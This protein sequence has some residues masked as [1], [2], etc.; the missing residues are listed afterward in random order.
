MGTRS[1]VARPMAAND[2]RCGDGAERQRE[3]R[4]ST[5]RHVL[6]TREQVIALIMHM[7]T[8]DTDYARTVMLREHEFHPEWDLLAAIR[9]VMERQ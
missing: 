3:T 4:L 9:E 1:S 6:V 2:P 5:R 7:K 8:L